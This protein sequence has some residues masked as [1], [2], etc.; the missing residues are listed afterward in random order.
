[1]EKESKKKFS[2][3]VMSLLAC[4]L[5]LL[6]LMIPAV[7][8]DIDLVPWPAGSPFPP[9]PE[10]M[11]AFHYP[12]SGWLNFTSPPDLSACKGDPY[13]NLTNYVR[14]GVRNG[15]SEGASS[16]KVRLYADD[17]LIGENTTSGLGAGEAI[18]IGFEWTPTGGEDPLTWTD[19]AQ[20][21]LGTYTDTSRTYTLKVVVDAANEVEES[22]EANNNK[23]ESKKVVWNG[24]TADEPLQNYVHGT[25]KGGIIYT[26]GDGVYTGMGENKYGMY[27]NFNYNLQIPGTAKQARLYFY[28][29]W[30]KVNQTIGTSTY[31]C[32]KI[33]VTLKT[34]SGDVHE[35]SMDKSYNDHKGD[36]G[37]WR[38]PWGT[39]AYNITGYVSES[40]TYVVNFTN[41]NHEQGEEGYDADWAGVYAPAA[42]AI[43]V[44]YENATAPEREYWINE[45]ADVLI[46]G[47]RIDGGFLALEECLNNAT[48]GG[49]I[50]LSKVKNATLGVVSPW[51]E[52]ANN[53]LYF[54]NEELGRGVYCG[55]S[56]PCTQELSGISMTIGKSGAQVGINATNV[57]NC[58]SASNNRVTQGDNTDM[59]MPVNAFL[60]VEYEEALSKPDLVITDKWVCWPDNCTI[61]YNITNVGNG[62]A[63]A[64][65]NTTLYVD[66]NET[67]LDEVPVELVPNASYIGCFNYTWAY[68]PPEDN[69]TVCADNNNTV[70]ESNETNNCLTD[71][72]MCGDVTGDRWIMTDDADLVYDIV[73]EVPGRAFVTSNWA[74]DVNGDGWILTDDADLVY[75]VVWEV[76]GRN[77]NCCCMD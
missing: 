27:N 59:M 63:P 7:S 49:S 56:A 60:V 30:A 5:L 50:D 62:T 28:Y 21:A 6:V 41:L 76:P 34:P 65:H 75:D 2:K 35:L 53:V 25:V 29:C 40:G 45:G 66:G 52:A 54:N 13:F 33:G 38:Q 22:N 12:E 19:T 9:P 43:L 77:L 46:G 47:R 36:Q 69:I 72:W 3:F 37:S 74:G 39:Y 24:Y 58:L 1:M 10:Y 73:W 17:T 20:G 8:A 14:A 71:I 44:V 23:S 64:G 32:P 26:T 16:F 48:F 57:T 67:A 51:G 15:G 61:C 55:D 70:D 31:K 18:F 4:T 68:T 11:H 42:P